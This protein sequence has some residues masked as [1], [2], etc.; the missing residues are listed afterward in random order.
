M[1]HV[2]VYFLSTF[3]LYKFYSTRFAQ[4]Y[5]F[6]PTSP[7]GQNCFLTREVLFYFHE[8]FLP[9]HGLDFSWI[10]LCQDGQLYVSCKMEPS[11]CFYTVLLSV[12]SF[13]ESGSVSLL[14]FLLVWQFIF[15]VCPCWK[16]VEKQL[17]FCGNVIFYWEDKKTKRQMQWRKPSYFSY[18]QKRTAI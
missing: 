11:K 6:H 13:A 18:H 10:Q 2:F 3:L 9:K 1:Q 16:T 5:S 15:Q 14:G 8:T 12:E 17:I 7:P 4:V